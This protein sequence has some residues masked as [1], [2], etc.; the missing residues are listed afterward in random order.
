MT[1]LGS[2]EQNVA[3]M[4]GRI[5]GKIDTLSTGQANIITRID[6]LDTRVQALEGESISRLADE[7]S[8]RK[9]TALIAAA[10]GG[11]MSA[12]VTIGAAIIPSFLKS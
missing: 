9:W 11:I 2:P 10:I 8:S 4:L 5:D 1:D 3:F 6:S 7:K 12:A